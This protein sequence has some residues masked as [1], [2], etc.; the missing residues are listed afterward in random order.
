MGFEAPANLACHQLHGRCSSHVTKNIE[1]NIILTNVRGDLSVEFPS[2]QGF[3]P[4]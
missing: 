4:A 2:Y 3:R 1:P